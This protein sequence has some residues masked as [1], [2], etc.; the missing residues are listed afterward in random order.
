MKKIL[1]KIHSFGRWIKAVDRTME[2][3]PG[4]GWEEALSIY[5]AQADA[6]HSS[7]QK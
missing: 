4:D 1:G 7:P 3:L 6:F 2:R 5:K